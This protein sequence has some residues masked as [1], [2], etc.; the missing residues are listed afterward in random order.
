MLKTI[1][2]T[3]P[4]PLLVKIDQAVTE[5]ATN[6]S[7]F[8]REAFEMALSRLELAEKERLDAEGYTRQPVKPG[9]VDVW[10][11]IQDWGER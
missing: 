2:I 10:Q 1:Q 8:A 5:Q 3:L 11:D 9:E 6:R 7:A 4:E